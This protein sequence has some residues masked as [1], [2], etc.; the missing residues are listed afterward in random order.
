M[1]GTLLA[2]EM[3]TE[4]FEEVAKRLAEATDA[5]DYQAFASNLADQKEPN[6]GEESEWVRRVRQFKN[7]SGKLEGVELL[8][9]DPPDGAFFELKYD[10]GSAELFL[11]LDDE[12][13]AT[14]VNIRPTDHPCASFGG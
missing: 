10:H 2:A 1:P 14:E 3:N 8:E 11:I 9:L 4:K 6:E 5:V 13:Q 12:G 7:H